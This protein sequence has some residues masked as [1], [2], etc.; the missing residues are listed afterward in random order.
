MLFSPGLRFGSSIPGGE[1]GGMRLAPNRSPLRRPRMTEPLIHHAAPSCAPKATRQ[2]RPMAWASARTCRRSPRPAPV[3]IPPSPLPSAPCSRVPGSALPNAGCVPPASACNRLRI[4]RLPRAPSRACRDDLS[5][6]RSGM[7]SD[8]TLR[9]PSLPCH[10][11][12]SA[13]LRF[14]SSATHQ[15]RAEL[16][17]QIFKS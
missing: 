12:F 16:Q 2:F 6:L 14:D 9:T 1:D 8:R 11:N 3:T 15:T 4:P 5:P 17:S 10:P 13:P 7:T